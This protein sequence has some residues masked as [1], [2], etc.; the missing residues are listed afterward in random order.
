MN[1]F[2]TKYAP[3]KKEKTVYKKNVR[4]QDDESK[5]I[6]SCSS[7]DDFV[8]VKDLI[9]SAKRGAPRKKRLK[10]SHEFESKNKSNIKQHSEMRTAR[11]PTQYQQCQNTG[12]NKAG[13]EAWHRRQGLSYSY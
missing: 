9:V 8:A 10:G 12:H 13:C 6:S 4:I 3:R 1:G 7:S 11:K 5:T 2:I